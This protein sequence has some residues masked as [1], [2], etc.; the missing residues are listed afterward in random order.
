MSCFETKR[1][2]GAPTIVA[3]DGCDVRV[4]LALAGGGM[5]HFELAAGRVSIAVTHR[6]V[7]EIWYVVSGSGKMWRRNDVL[8]EIVD[9]EPGVCLTIPLGTHFQFRASADSGLGVV[10]VTMPP[11]PGEQE[12]RVVTGPWMPGTPDADEPIRF[13]TGRP[14]VLAGLR[15]RHPLATA[16]TGIAAQWRDAVRSSW[17]PGRVGSTC[18]GVMCGADATGLEYMC[19]IEV[20]SLAELPEG[21]GK[22]RVPAQTYAVF[23]H[24]AASS[25]RTTWERA[26]DWLSKSGFESAHLPDFEVYGSGCDPLTAAGPIEVWVGVVER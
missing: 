25:L 14:M 9:L 20:A 5:A 2:P 18:F 10:G 12:A 17:P 1:L 16:A 19:A 26:F 8:E 3:P 23:A 6:T 21:T 13:E 22:M 11:W 15:R 7:E 4:L 24:D